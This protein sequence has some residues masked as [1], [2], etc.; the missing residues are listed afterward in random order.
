VA[1]PLEKPSSDHDG[2]T[3]NGIDAAALKL[4]RAFARL[5]SAVSRASEGH[6]SL[7]ADGDKLNLLLREADKEIVR[8]K[9][10]AGTVSKRL[11]RTIGMLEKMETQPQ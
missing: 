3:L 6:H 5:E 8:L 4:E 10:V 11:D 9:E 1:Q 7:K 2:G